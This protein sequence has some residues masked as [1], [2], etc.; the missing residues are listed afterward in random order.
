MTVEGQTHN[1]NR[2]SESALRNGLS[3]FCV[4]DEVFSR[5]CRFCGMLQGHA[6]N[7]SA[8]VLNLYPLGC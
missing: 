2:T 6:M 5:I 3:F 8:M 4:L 1:N 7:T